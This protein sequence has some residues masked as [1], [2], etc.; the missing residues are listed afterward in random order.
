MR[1]SENA[2]PGLAQAGVR[3]TL[4]NAIP[5]KI[6]RIMGLKAETPGKARSAKAAAA[7]PHVSSR[8]GTTD[9][10]PPSAPL[11]GPEMAAA[12]TFG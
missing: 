9:S 11:G 8:P 5:M 1:R 3:M 4:W 10:A 7:M 2:T 12:E 6:D